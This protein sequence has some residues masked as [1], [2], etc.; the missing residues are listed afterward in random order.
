[1]QPF[2]AYLD[3]R[4]KQSWF[5]LRFQMAFDDSIGRR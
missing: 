5:P 4:E 2:A 3:L 1:M